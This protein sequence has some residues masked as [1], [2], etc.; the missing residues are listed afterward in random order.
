MILRILLHGIVI[1]VFELGLGLLPSV[2]RVIVV[3]KY[4]L[5]RNLL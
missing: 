2:L 3:V 4:Y 1:M 5:G